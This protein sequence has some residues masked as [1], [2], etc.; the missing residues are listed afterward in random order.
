MRFDSRIQCDGGSSVFAG[1]VAAVSY[2]AAGPCRPRAASRWLSRCPE[3][4]RL[5]RAYAVREIRKEAAA[6][7]R[8]YLLFVAARFFAPGDVV[9]RIAVATFPWRRN[10][11]CLRPIDAREMA[12]SETRLASRFLFGKGFHDF[13]RSDGDLIDP[14]SDS[15]VDGIGDRGHDREKRALPDFLSA[16]WAARIRFLDQLGDHFGHIQRGWTLVFQDRRE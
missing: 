3:C 1:P 5:L 9:H 11:Q 4:A 16:K 12:R 8:E 6:S 14:H 2:S 13:F 15:V 7:W 10:A